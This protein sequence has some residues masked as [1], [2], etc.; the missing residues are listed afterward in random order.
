ML[1]QETNLSNSKRTEIVRGMPSDFNGINYPRKMKTHVHKQSSMKIPIVTSQRT[2]P[3]NSPGVQQVFIC[4]DDYI[5]KVWYNGSVV[6][7][8][9]AISACI[10]I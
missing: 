2:Q 5:N 9:N 8:Y 4:L 1:G 3:G 10:M 6:C 7:Q